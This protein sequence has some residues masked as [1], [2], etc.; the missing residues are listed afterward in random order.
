MPLR[1]H[2][3]TAE[4]PPRA[5]RRHAA[6]GFP[7]TQAPRVPSPPVMAVGH[8]SDESLRGGCKGFLRQPSLR[9]P[10]TRLPVT[11]PRP[12]PTGYTVP[13]ENAPNTCE[14]SRRSAVGPPGRRPHTPASPRGPR[15]GPG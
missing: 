4:G 6:V 1:L 5:G 13:R 3:S 15:T 14:R 9:L 10:E 7:Y 12:R 11:P 8:S 2:A